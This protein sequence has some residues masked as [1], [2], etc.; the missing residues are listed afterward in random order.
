L[1]LASRYGEE[2]LEKAC[3]LAYV[4]GATRYKHV[5]LILKNKTE[6]TV[7]H[8]APPTPV[9]AHENIRGADYYK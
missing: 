4:S 9:I 3:A 6:D 8:Q 2:R 1:R 5:E 7:H